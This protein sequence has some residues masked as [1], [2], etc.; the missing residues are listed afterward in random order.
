MT[1]TPKII[2]LLLHLPSSNRTPADTRG[3]TFSESHLG[4]RA[5]PGS[6]PRR[7]HHRP[8]KESRPLTHLTNT[9]LYLLSSWAKHSPKVGAPQGHTSLVVS[10]VYVDKPNCFR[11][12]KDGL[13]TKSLHAAISQFLRASVCVCVC[14]C[15]IY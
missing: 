11:I 2:Y 15:V 1:K 3:E 8:P 5:A 14:V 6:S 7:R 10:T 13:K 12:E 4:G 9:A